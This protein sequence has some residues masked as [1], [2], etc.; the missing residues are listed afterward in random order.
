MGIFGLKKKHPAIEM[1]ELERKLSDA[2]EQLKTVTDEKQLLETELNKLRSARGEKQ[3]TG[4]LLKDSEKYK[5]KMMEYYHQ[6]LL[7]SILVSR[8]KDHFDENE[9]RTIPELKEL[10]QPDNEHIKD[11]INKISK[12][13]D[14]ETHLLEACEK[15]VGE[16]GD[17]HSA[18]GLD[19]PF[20]ISIEEM[21]ENNVADYE[22]KAILL[23]S[24]LRKLGADSSVLI[25]ELTDGS[26]RPLVIISLEDKVVLLDPN[27]G[28]SFYQ[29]FDSRP[30]VL[31]E[32]EF[33]G[34]KISRILYMFNDR[35]Y[36]SYE[37][38]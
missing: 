32:Y 35:E 20:W 36:K 21:L 30:V 8:Y 38:E 14:P 16:I 7:Y 17:V 15:A 23:C 24:I 27:K 22:D 1:K 25:I 12:E 37:E 31:D 3:T 19:V 13:T 5:N 34:N 29:Y 28:H 9:T 18:P 2:E 4:D 6:L 11:I 33:D 26:T 10:I